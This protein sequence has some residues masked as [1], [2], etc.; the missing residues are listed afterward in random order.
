MAAR[1]FTTIPYPVTIPDYQTYLGTYPGRY[2]YIPQNMTRS[3]NG[4]C[5]ALCTARNRRYNKSPAID[6]HRRGRQYDSPKKHKYARSFIPFLIQLIYQ[7][8][9]CIHI[10]TPALSFSTATTDCADEAAAGVPLCAGV[11]PAR[12]WPSE[13]E[14]VCQRGEADDEH[15]LSRRKC[16]QHVD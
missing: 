16:C 1:Q 11:A 4:D 13:A 14:T 12:G 8:V 5:Y 3:F 10:P 15:V 6:T 9:L 2:L 7:P